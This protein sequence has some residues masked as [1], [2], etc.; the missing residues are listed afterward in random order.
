VIVGIE[1]GLG[2]VGNG[3]ISRVSLTIN[4]VL[5]A[6]VDGE[7]GG[8]VDERSRLG[9]R[10]G[11]GGVPE[12]AAEVY[13]SEL[14]GKD[15]SIGVRCGTSAVVGETRVLVTIDQLVVAL[16]GALARRVVGTEP[17]GVSRRATRDA[18]KIRVGVGG[19]GLG[20]ASGGVD[21]RLH[22]RRAAIEGSPLAVD[23][24][25]SEAAR[26]PNTSRI[27]DIREKVLGSA[28]GINIGEEVR[29]FDGVIPGTS[30]C[31]V[32]CGG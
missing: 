1:D 26:Q 19:I 16:D 21:L 22:G 30:S 4:V 5:S 9:I 31:E 15:V 28:I 24:S 23:A 32:I 12:S 20:A 7:V 3:Q 27:L 10:S 29:R 13:R 17:G 18:C 2:W 14:V 25:D 11:V 8:F 6:T